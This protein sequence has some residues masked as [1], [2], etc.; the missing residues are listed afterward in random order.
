MYSIEWRDTALNDLAAGW[1]VADAALRSDITASIH[2]IERRLKR[3]PER[4]GE[5][6]APG[7]R[8]MIL[9]PLTVTF[10][11]NARLSRVVIPAYGYVDA[12]VERERFP[13]EQYPV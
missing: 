8:V 12:K 4:A 5:S 3:S 13:P 11:V 7:T 6:R 10:H 1:L 9:N 2:E